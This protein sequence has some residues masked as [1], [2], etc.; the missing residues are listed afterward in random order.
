VLQ[1][2]HCFKLLAHFHDNH[3]DDVIPLL[4]KHFVGSHILSVAMEAQRIIIDKV[5]TKTWSDVASLKQL[6]QNMSLIKRQRLSHM[7]L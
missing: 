5:K 7:I 2:G 6:I 1:I 3:P 4:C